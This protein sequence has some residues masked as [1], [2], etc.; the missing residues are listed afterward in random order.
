[1]AAGSEAALPGRHSSSSCS[2][3]RVSPSCS[4]WAA[5]P[6]ATTLEVAIYQSL[7]ATSIRNAP[8][9]WPSCSWHSAPRWHS[10]PRNWGG[11]A[12]GWP[13]LRL[14]AK[15][16]D[17]KRPSARLQRRRGD[18]PRPAAAASP[19]CRPRQCGPVP[20][21]S[22]ALAAEGHGDEPCPGRR[23]CGPRLCARLAA[24]RAGGA[25]QR[26]AQGCGACR[27]HLL[28]RSAGSACH[29][30]V[31]QRHRLCHDGGACGFPGDRHECADV[32]SLRRHGPAASARPI[33]RC[34]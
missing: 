16:F 10:S 31:H 7:R 14:G 4:R 1:M 28:D 3:P 13:M 19:A 5:D 21:Q 30:L 34:A 25:Q 26:V 29:W 24:R 18:P 20:H 17:G 9:C 22:L 8:P 27:A 11:L 33:S 23:Q 15:R 6:R 2:A 12:Q 32:A